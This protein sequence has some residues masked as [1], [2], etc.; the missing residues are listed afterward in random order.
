VSRWT[1]KSP[2]FPLTPFISFARTNFLEF[3]L[4]TMIWNM[5]SILDYSNISHLHFTKMSS[6]VLKFSKI[7]SKSIKIWKK[8]GN[9]RKTKTNIRISI[10]KIFIIVV[11]YSYI[12]IFHSDPLLRENARNS[13]SRTE[14]FIDAKAKCHYTIAVARIDVMLVLSP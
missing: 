1:R 6:N 7:W 12:F 9:S 13:Y 3:R 5:V 8:T 14:C 2:L 11:L 10:I 4:L